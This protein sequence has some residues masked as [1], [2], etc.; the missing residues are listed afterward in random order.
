MIKS[1]HY[2]FVRRDYISML[3]LITSTS[4][5]DYFHDTEAIVIYSNEL[6]FCTNNVPPFKF[7]S[8]SNLGDSLNHIGS[9]QADLDNFILSNPEYFI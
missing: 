7:S 5:L 3:L 4:S 8:T 1:G 6:G 9:S 2:Y